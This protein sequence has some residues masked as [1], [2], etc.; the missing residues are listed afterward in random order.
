ME[1][2]EIKKKIVTMLIKARTYSNAF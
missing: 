2:A 1:E